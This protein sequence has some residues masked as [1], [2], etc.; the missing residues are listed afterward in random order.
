MLVIRLKRVG[1]KNKPYYRMVVA[2][3]TKAVSGKFIE[4]L[5]AIDPHQK[6]YD[7][8]KE[9]IEKWLANGAKPSDTAFNLLVKEGILD[10]P[11]RKIRIKKKKKEEKKEEGA[12]EEKKEAKPEESKPEEN[13]KEAEKTETEKTEKKE[14]KK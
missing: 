2:E 10:A 11:K 3:K 12:S 7:L 5:G 6:K 14:D 1:K 4:T 8:K 9:K 13:P